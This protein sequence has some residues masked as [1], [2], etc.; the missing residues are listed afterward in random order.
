MG[1]QTT[2]IATSGTSTASDGN[3]GEEDETPVPST[4][5]KG[6]TPD[7]GANTKTEENGNLVATYAL[8][9]VVIVLA[10]ILFK[11]NRS[12]KYIKFER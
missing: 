8:P 12:K 5:K 11:R 1:I 9:M 7:T 3:S 10:G 2:R 4:S 6:I